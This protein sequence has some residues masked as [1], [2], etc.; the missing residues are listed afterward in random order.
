MGLK[1]LT[2]LALASV[3]L[4]ANPPLPVKA[5]EPVRAELH[6]DADRLKAGEIL[7]M[8]VNLHNTTAKEITVGLFT[9][10]CA[11]PTITDKKRDKQ[12]LWWAPAT[13]MPVKPST[14][15]LKPEQECVVASYALKAIDTNIEGKGSSELSKLLRP[16]DWPDSAGLPLNTGLMSAVK[17]SYV[18]QIVLH[19]NSINGAP[20]PALV[21]TDS[22]TFQIVD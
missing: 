4:V 18:V 20:S 2:L 17:G 7:H 15:V 3:L 11:I 14:L 21:K 16:K 19:F 9:P 10:Y 5:Y 22:K 13:N 1:Q 8:T 6:L 12:A